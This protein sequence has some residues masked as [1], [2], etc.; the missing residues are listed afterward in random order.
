MTETIQ[1]MVVYQSETGAISLKS[2]DIVEKIWATQKQM[3][4]LFDVEIPTINE[5]IKAI[6]SSEELDKIQLLGNSE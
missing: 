5:H 2:D 4:Q 1:N 6:F 3:A